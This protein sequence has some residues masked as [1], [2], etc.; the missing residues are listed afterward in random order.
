MDRLTTDRESTASFAD[1][2]SQLHPH[3]FIRGSQFEA[4]CCWFLLHSPVYRPLVRRVWFWRDW[5]GRWGADAGIDLVAET[6]DGSLWAIQA[7]AYAPDHAITKADVDTFL[8]ESA[9]SQFAFR[10]LVATTN[11]IGSTARRIIDQ[12]EKP[13]HL[14]MLADLEHAEVT[15]PVSPDD[16]QAPPVAPR[17][18]LPH[19]R[20]AVAAVLRGFAKTD[21]GQLLMACGTGKTLTALWLTE[22]LL[23]ERTLVLLPSLS[24]LAQTLR[25]WT[26]NASRPF[27]FLAVCS[28]ETVVDDDQIVGRTSQLGVPVTTDPTT[29]ADFL[30]EPGTR[31]VFA[32]YQS[33]PRLTEAFVRGA[34][35]FDLVIADEAHRCTGPAAGAFATVLDQRRIPAARRLFMTATPRYFTERLRRESGEAEFE[36]VSMDDEAAFGP[37]FH[38]LSFAG[39]IERDLL[40]DYRVVVIG[41]DDADYR[42]YAEEGRFVTT[43]GQSTTDARSLAGAIGLAKAAQTYNLRKVVSFHSR[44]K[45]ARAFSTDFPEVVAW[46]PPYE[47]P[48]G[49]IW[50]RVI[51]GDMPSGER[52]MLLSRFRD[53][54]ENERALLS[55]ARCL[56]E[57]VDIPSI[58]GVAFLDPRRSQIDVV[59]A[60]GRAIRRS[61]DKILGTVVVPVFV[62][63]AADPESALDASAFRPVWEVLKALR[64]HDEVLAEQLD[65]LRRELGRRRTNDIVL[66]AKLHVDLPVAV[67]EDFARAFRARLVEQ[68]TSSWE[69][70]YGVLCRF[71]KREGHSL[72][73]AD[74]EEDGV[75]L[76]KWV[77]KQRARRKQ[78]QLSEERMQRLQALPG[79]RWEPLEERW[80]EGYAA[81]LRFAESTGHV[82][83]P[84]RHVEDGF[85]LGRWVAN[86][87]VRSRNEADRG[88]RLEAV[89]GWS[90]R[91][92]V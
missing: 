81:L 23:S 79:W 63:A 13:A 55:N 7:K 76:G 54:R 4:I 85:K 26:T 71:V 61:P 30:G 42:A 92:R 62:D 10:L 21:R 29:V 9:R 68:A 73:P 67:G 34:P 37:V 91:G 69:A 24:L 78:D 64:A 53:L 66:P 22:A 3:P 39:A 19:Q 12:Q 36:V 58:D 40:A 5:P 51:S 33:S 25:Q 17:I 89:P 16:L 35:S 6:H 27:A 82:R 77:S 15:W 47:R 31:V 87:R 52:D 38:R 59:Q 84:L 41:V 57:G 45:G 43:D 88:S 11:R 50:A 49:Q 70:S 75:Q 2:I 83:V 32:T 14:L 56:A 80:E 48:S 65:E 28:D 46:L 74:H 90:W 18:P 86:Q 1:L 72:V 60:V 8:S 44:V 20:E